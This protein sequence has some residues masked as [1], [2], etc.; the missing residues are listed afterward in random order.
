MQ[1]T[2]YAFGIVLSALL[3]CSCNMYSGFAAPGSDSE[4]IE[5]AQKCL[6]DR[7]FGCAIVNYN[8][9][10]STNEKNKRLCLVNMARAG[11]GVSELV[12]IISNS[13]T[14]ATIVGEIAQELLPYSE[15][16]ETAG[17]AAV[18]ACEAYSTA[19]SGDTATLLASLSYLVDCSVRVA[20]TD[21][22]VATSD[23]GTTSCNST[24]AGNSNGLITQSDI[25]GHSATGALSVGNPGM[26][27]ADVHACLQDLNDAAALT[28][29]LSAGGLGDIAN[30][31]LSLSSVY[32][33]GADDLGRKALGQSMP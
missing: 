12:Q 26:C 32:G 31:I 6:A 25:G 22:L 29:A 27:Q 23:G 19:V 20:K 7:D 2:K 16:K 33:A 10:S 18:T 1:K 21:T 13:G 9:L 3:L 5:E 24:T 11:L 14:G 8:K 15:E 17:A 4:Y 30:N 28:G